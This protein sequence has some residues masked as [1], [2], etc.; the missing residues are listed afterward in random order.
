GGGGGQGSNVAPGGAGQPGAPD[1]TRA[2]GGTGG[3]GEAA[4]GLGSGGATLAGA[5]GTDDN[6][7]GAGG[8]GGGAGHVVI[9]GQ[10]RQLDAAAKVS[11]AAS[12][13]P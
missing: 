1:T 6:D 10:S 8:G 7:H 4:G 5:P 13:L 12:I 11:P 9:A 3:D 2:L